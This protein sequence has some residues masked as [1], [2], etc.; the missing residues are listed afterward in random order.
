MDLDGFCN[1]CAKWGVG[2]ALETVPRTADYEQLAEACRGRADEARRR[3]D[4]AG[5]DRLASA[6]Q[7]L[8]Y[9]SLPYDLT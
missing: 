7:Y 8:L 4:H 5:A 3:G 1:V 2:V 6:A 9:L